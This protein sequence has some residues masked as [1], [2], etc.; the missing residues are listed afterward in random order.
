M[1]VTDN[2]VLFGEQLLNR[3]IIILVLVIF[4]AELLLTSCGYKSTIIGV[5]TE[6]IATLTFQS[7]GTVISRFMGL[8]AEGNYFFLDKDTLR[9]TFFG[10]SIDY[11][12]NISHGTMYLISNGIILTYIKIK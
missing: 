5:W 2:N 1:I 12:L 6:K 9:M 4:L 8:K 10:K 11:K 7:D 3:K